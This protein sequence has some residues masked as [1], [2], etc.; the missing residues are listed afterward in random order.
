VDAGEV[1]EVSVLQMLP[2]AV[3]VGRL[4]VI[5][6]QDGHRAGEQTLREALAIE[7]EQ[8]RGHGNWFHFGLCDLLAQQL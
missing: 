4:E 1:K 8:G 5:G 7:R 2:R 3:G 6:I